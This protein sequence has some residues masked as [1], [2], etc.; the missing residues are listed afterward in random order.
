MLSV[1]DYNVCKS[2]ILNN[3]WN[4]QMLALGIFL[5][6]VSVKLDTFYIRRC[7]IYREAS[8]IHCVGKTNSMQDENK[9]YMNMLRFSPL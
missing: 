1:V 7:L 4:R 9:I 5:N 8:K 2:A 3:K 6:L